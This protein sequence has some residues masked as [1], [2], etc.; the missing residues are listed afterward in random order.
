MSKDVT[1]PPDK[2]ATRLEEKNTVVCEKRSL[3]FGRMREHY[4]P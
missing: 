4:V 1:G 2:I 3:N